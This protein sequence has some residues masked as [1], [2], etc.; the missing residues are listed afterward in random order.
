MDN[1]NRLHQQT[2]YG[3]HL[4]RLHN[5]TQ[6]NFS[7]PKNNNLPNNNQ[8]L[9]YK[10]DKMP[11]LLKNTLH[12]FGNYSKAYLNKLRMGAISAWSALSLHLILGIKVSCNFDNFLGLD[13]VILKLMNK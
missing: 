12:E 1:N 11:V 7:Q 5:A 6:I 10:S 4:L 8:L 9:T 13:R 2:F 3:N